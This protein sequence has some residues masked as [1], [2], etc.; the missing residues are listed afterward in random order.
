MQF[1]VWDDGC[2]QHIVTS[3][4][5]LVTSERGYWRD[6]DLLTSICMARAGLTLAE[7]VDPLLLLGPAQAAAWAAA[8]D[9]GAQARPQRVPAVMSGLA[10]QEVAE[11]HRKLTGEAGARA[12]GGGGGSAEWP[13]AAAGAGNGA[14]V[15]VPAALHGRLRMQSYEELRARQYEKGFNPLHGQVRGRSRGW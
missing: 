6:H 15:M 13:G 8:P 10:P 11:L 2:Y 14:A 12:R 7:P 9:G 4:P 3:H 5:E 1:G